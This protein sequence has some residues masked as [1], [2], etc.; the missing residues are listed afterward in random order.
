MGLGHSGSVREETGSSTGKRGSSF[1]GFGHE[2]GI[3]AWDLV[4]PSPKGSTTSSFQQREVES[5]LCS[6][7][8]ISLEV[9]GKK[10]KKSRLFSGNVVSVL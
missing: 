8:Q 10:S 5:A 7:V 1:R 4:C 9:Q 3:K 2:K 6:N